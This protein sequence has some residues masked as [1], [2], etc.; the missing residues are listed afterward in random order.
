ME[1]KKGIL[2]HWW[3]KVKGDKKIVKIVNST[4]KFRLIPEVK[5]S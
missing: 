5:S 3:H 4:F 1:G 2:D